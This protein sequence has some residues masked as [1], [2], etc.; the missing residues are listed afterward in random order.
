MKVQIKYPKAKCPICGKTYTKHHNR[1]KY[2][3]DECRKEAKRRQDTKHKLNWWYKNK[4]HLNQTRLGTIC[5]SQHRNPDPDREAEIVKN[6]KQR[7]GL[8]TS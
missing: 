3:S 8:D 4:T 5:I 1:Q 7:L 2:C 6:E